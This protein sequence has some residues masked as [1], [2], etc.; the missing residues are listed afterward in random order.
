MSHGVMAFLWPATVVFGL[1][2]ACSLYFHE[3]R[4]GLATR[5]RYVVGFMVSIDYLVF[6][7]FPFAFMGGIYKELLIPYLYPITLARFL[8]ALTFRSRGT[9]IYI[10]TARFMQAVTF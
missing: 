7:A 10:N 4:V 1:G 5:A 9:Y 6:W 2:C 8:H 3:R